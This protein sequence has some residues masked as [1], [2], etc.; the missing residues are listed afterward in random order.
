MG[1]GGT[2]GGNGGKVSLS[3]KS[4]RAGCTM[5]RGSP[6]PESWA[7]LISMSEPH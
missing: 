2:Y 5:E 6:S 4:R 3:C 7:L 1:D